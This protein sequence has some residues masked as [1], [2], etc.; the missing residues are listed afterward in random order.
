MKKE[1][2]IYTIIERD[3][4]AKFYY[5]GT[6][7]HPVRRTVIVIEETDNL[8]QGY[9]LRSGS[10]ICGFKDAPIRGF[11]KDRIALVKQCGRRLRKRTPDNLLNSTTLQR[12]G[13]LEIIKDGV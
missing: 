13:L 12:S 3:P 2:K 1:R 8:I 6:H 7:S 10:K 11:R 5:Q 4:V 9:E